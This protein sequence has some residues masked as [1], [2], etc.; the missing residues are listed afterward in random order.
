MDKETEAQRSIF[1]I[2]EAHRVLSGYKLGRKS[3]MRKV[4]LKQEC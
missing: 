2:R 3:F 4:A 1:H